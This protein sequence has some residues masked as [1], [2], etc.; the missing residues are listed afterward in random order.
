M[1]TPLNLKIVF[2]IARPAVLLALLFFILL[3]GNGRVSHMH[4]SVTTSVPL[5]LLG[6]TFHP[7]VSI[8]HVSV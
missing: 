4:G 7:I 1:K 2:R 3:A 8:N 5:S 6:V